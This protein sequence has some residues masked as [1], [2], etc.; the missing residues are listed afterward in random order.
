MC[1]VDVCICDEVCVCVNVCAYQSVVILN[2]DGVILQLYHVWRLNPL[3][4]TISTTGSSRSRSRP[5][6]PRSPCPLLLLVLSLLLHH[7]VPEGWLVD[8]LEVECLDDLPVIPVQPHSRR[9]VVAPRAPSRVAVVRVL[10]QRTSGD[11]GSAALE[12]LDASRLNRRQGRTRHTGGLVTGGRRGVA[13][14]VP[15]SP[16]VSACI[17]WLVAAVR[18]ISPAAATTVAIRLV[19]IP[20]TIT[21]IPTSTIAPTTTMAVAVSLPVPMAMSAALSLLPLPGGVERLWELRHDDLHPAKR[22]LLVSLLRL[23]LLPLRLDDLEG[24]CALELLGALLVG[25]DV[26]HHRIVVALH[27]ILLGLDVLQGRRLLHHELHGHTTVG[28]EVLALDAKGHRPPLP[29]LVQQG[30]D[31]HQPPGLVPPLA[32]LD[33]LHL[34]V[35]RL[36]VDGRTDAL[37]RDVLEAL[38]LVGGGC[39]TGGAL[40]HLGYCGR[41]S[42]LPPVRL[43]GGRSQPVSS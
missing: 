22:R 15:V 36:V 18:F 10:D 37:E 11:D 5:S 2:D 34:L 21:P 27:N 38:A 17:M 43:A 23:H 39:G 32:Q 30:L 26:L 31:V 14:S 16:I 19:A 42:P 3:V 28:E 9:V 25:V 35:G 24:L 12:R 29:L 33:G 41:S 1:M 7:A 40:A 4:A 13:R 6:E 8:Q 20:T